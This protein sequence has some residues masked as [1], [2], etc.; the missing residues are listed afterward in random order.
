[1]FASKDAEIADLKKRLAATEK[2]RAEL[3]KAHAPCDNLIA[4][5]RKQLAAL[6]LTR[7]Y[8]KVSGAHAAVIRNACCT[9]SQ[10]IACVM[11]GLGKPRRA[12]HACSHGMMQRE[13]DKLK[14]ELDELRKAHAPCPDIIAGLKKDLAA[15]QAEHEPCAAQIKKLKA[16]LARLDK[17][18]AQELEKEEALAKELAEEKRKEAELEQSLKKTKADLEKD[19]RDLAEDKKVRARGPGGR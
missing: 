7:D 6:E 4:S 13:L 9:C 12:A 1:M 3:E 18:L 17:E 19:E 11:Y 8:A 5:L 15:A 10:G 16:H 14:A 2:Q